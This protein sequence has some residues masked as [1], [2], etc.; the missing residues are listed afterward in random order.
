MSA[1]QVAWAFVAMGIASI[2]GALVS[3]R[4]SDRVGRKPVILFCYI[5]LI[6]MFAL[7]SWWMQDMNTVLVWFFVAMLLASSRQGAGSAW[8]S[9]LVTAERRGILLSGSVAVGQI[10][11]ALGAAVAALVYARLDSAGFVLNTLIAAVV[12][13]AMVLIVAFMLPETRQVKEG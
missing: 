5:P 10:G 1:R 11:S 7:A 13:V 6:A 12:G 9:E 2:I 3:G 8:A 4:V